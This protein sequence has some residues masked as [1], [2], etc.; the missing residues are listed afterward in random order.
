MAEEP[1]VRYFLAELLGKGENDPEV[2]TS[3]D[4]IGKKGWAA[5]LLGKQKDG[6]Y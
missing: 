6:K 1:S 5:Q 4:A 3:R 2:R